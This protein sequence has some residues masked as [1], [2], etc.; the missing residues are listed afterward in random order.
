MRL[1]KAFGRFLNRLL[2]RLFPE[3]HLWILR[4][5]NQSVWVQRLLQSENLQQSSNQM[6]IN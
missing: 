5:S 2:A 3:V 4:Q 1:S 6:N